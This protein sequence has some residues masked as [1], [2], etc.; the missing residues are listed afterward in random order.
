MMELVPA[1]VMSHHGNHQKNWAAWI[2]KRNCEECQLW[3]E[4]ASDFL[5]RDGLPS[6][7]DA[8]TAVEAA[9]QL[10]GRPRG[11]ILSPT[12]QVLAIVVDLLR[13]HGSVTTLVR[14]KSVDIAV[15]YHLLIEGVEVVELYGKLRQKADQYMP[16]AEESPV[17]L[18]RKLDSSV[19]SVQSH[20]LSEF[21]R[22]VDEAEAKKRQVISALSARKTVL[23]DCLRR[24]EEVR[25]HMAALKE[26][27]ADL[28]REEN[29]RTMLGLPL[30]LAAKLDKEIKLFGWLVS[31]AAFWTAP[32]IPGVVS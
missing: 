29:Q 5:L 32:P 10:E 3:A 18:R 9:N 1:S 26:H 17:I 12:R 19:F 21:N 25:S 13:W 7:V 16:N 6:F 4:S 31:N 23:R 15:A 27:Y 28:K 11:I 14:S 8:L 20:W 22:L 2:L 24:P 30:T